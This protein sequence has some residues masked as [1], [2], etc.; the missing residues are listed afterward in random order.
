MPLFAFCVARG[1]YYSEQRG[2]T[3]RYARKLFFFAAVSQI[4]Y[5]VLSFLVYG[6]FRLNIGFTWLL[7]VVFMKTITSGE[8]P[9]ITGIMSLLVFLISLILPVDYGLYGV[10]FPCVFFLFMFRT[11]KTLYAFLAMAIL[12]VVYGIIN[13]EQI[14]IFSLAALPVLIFAKKYD[15]KIK[16]PRCFFYIFYP[17]HIA[18][19][20]AVKGVISC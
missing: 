18:V 3:A 6:C 19:L 10:I 15:E 12:Y 7:A 8:N 9:F 20:L 1:F 13:K 5:T 17:A 11:K 4:P 2:T 16:L 14:Q